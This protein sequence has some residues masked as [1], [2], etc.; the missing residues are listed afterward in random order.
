MGKN[1][2]RTALYSHSHSLSLSLSQTHRDR[3]REREIKSKTI[4]PGKKETPKSTHSVQIAVGQHG[5]KNEQITSTRPN[6]TQGCTLFQQWRDIKLCTLHIRQNKAWSVLVSIAGC[7]QCA[8]CSPFSN[9]PLI[10]QY[11]VIYRRQ[12][13]EFSL[14]R[15]CNSSSVLQFFHSFSRLSVFVWTRIFY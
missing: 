7:V 9:S 8:V 12:V 3:E 4:M 11:N 1:C 13:F 5:Q 15:N 6:W 2:K 14:L 10:M